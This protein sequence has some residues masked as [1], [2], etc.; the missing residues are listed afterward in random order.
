MA[1]QPDWNATIA[2][3]PGA[4]ILQ[5]L[6]WAQ[7][8]IQYG[9]QAEYITWQEENGVLRSADFFQGHARDHSRV[10]AAALV[11]SRTVRLVGFP[12][13]VLYVPKGPLL[14]WSEPALRRQ[15]LA[16]LLSLAKERMA[17][18]I[19]ID[20]DVKLGSGI[21]GEANSYDDLIGL[22]VQSEMAESGWLPSEEQ[23][24]FMN[25]VL[26]DLTLPEAELLANMKQ[27][28]RYNLRLAER[29]GVSVR[30]ADL[31]DFPLLYQ[32]YAETSVRDGFVIRD[33]AYYQKVW[34]TFM[35]AGMAQ[36]LIAEAAG[37]PIAG[38]FLFTFAGRAWYLYGMSFGAQ[39]E[40][41]PNYLL[42]WEAIRRAKHQNCSTYDLW[43]AP[44]HFDEADAMWGVYRFKVGLGGETVRQLGA[45]DLP[46]RPNLYRLYTQILPRILTIM[47]RRGQTKTRQQIG[48]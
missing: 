9:W 1:V 18:F 33:Q 23:I 45:W 17:I 20:P 31:A 48:G 46:V 4:H 41:M 44:D 37:E 15:V 27:K 29:K 22:A 40:K 28:T 39:R 30:A 32:M 25:T 26:I 7:V 19:K 3:L 36:A 21:P 38:L 47:R 11:L 43:G 8:K 13:R 2:A 6:E 42:Q 14:D 12:V 34:Q 5:T 35:Q 10:R 24:Q 16:D